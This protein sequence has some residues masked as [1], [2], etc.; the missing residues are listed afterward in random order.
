MRYFAVLTALPF[1]IAAPLTERAEAVGSGKYIVILKPT[2]SVPTQGTDIGLPGGSLLANVNKEH[3]YDVG[4]FKG[5]S[6]TLSD[7]QIAALRLDSNVAYIESDQQ[8]HTTGIR[9]MQASAQSGHVITQ[10]SAPSW[11]LGR[12]SHREKGNTDYLYHS[13]AGQG[14][15][16]YTVDTGVDASHPQFEGRAEQVKNFASNATTDDYGHGTHVAGI[17]GSLSHG[18]A[19]KTKLYGVK[20]LDKYGS[21]ILSNVIAGVAFA[22]NHS[23]TADCPNGAVINMSLG[24]PRSQAVND[25]AA[26]AYD[27]GV[28]IAVSAG[29]SGS[30]TENYSPSS[31][32]KAFTVGATNTTDDITEYS[33]YGCLLDCFAPGHDINSTWPGNQYQI[34]S[35]T[36][37]ASPHVVGLAAYF[38]GL[39]GKMDPDTLGN[40]IKAFSTKDVVGAILPNTSTPNF[41]SFNGIGEN[42]TGEI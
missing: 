37:M 32:P 2:A 14:T 26:A 41:F 33:N 9:H 15:C 40:I 27:A 1:I 31:E 11:G 18:V 6:A 5:Y 12:L 39:F 42:G 25:A 21:G 22:V 38:L 4:N 36:S 17:I 28:F 8:V 30:N 13:S 19:K 20:V 10:A 24:S 7:T 35:G 3:I 29:N 34:L 23:R 16:S